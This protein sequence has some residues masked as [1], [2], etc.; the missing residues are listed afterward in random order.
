MSTD[1]NA[2][3]QWSLENGQKAEA[4]DELPKLFSARVS[5]DDLHPDSLEVLGKLRSCEKPIVDEAILALMWCLE[6]E[7][8]KYGPLRKKVPGVRL[9]KGALQVF[10]REKTCGNHVDTRV[11]Q[12]MNEVSERTRNRTIARVQVNE[13]EAR[14][15]ADRSDNVVIA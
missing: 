13:A 6:Q 4:T 8:G 15:A 9:D 1:S 2:V 7:G 14:N 10:L 11:T 5:E 3:D 12:L